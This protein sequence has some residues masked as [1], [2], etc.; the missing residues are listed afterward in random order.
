M[1]IVF[2][3]PE[4]D[5]LVKVGGLADVVS[6][7]AIEL[8]RRGEQVT[9]ILPF[10]RG[11]DPKKFPAKDTG[12]NLKIPHDGTSHE[13]EIWT[14]EHEGVPIYLVSHKGYYG[15]EEIYGVRGTDYPDNALR[16]AF[17]AKAALETTR[18]LGM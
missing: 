9:V 13:A 8:H 11:I 16:F 14:V 7:L 2:V 3:T 1:N 18:A 15:R 12:I 4:M 10:Y 17:L 5:P 6:A